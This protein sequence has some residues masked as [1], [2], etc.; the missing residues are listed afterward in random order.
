MEENT[1]QNW[2][3]VNIIEEFSSKRFKEVED[4]KRVEEERNKIVQAFRE[5]QRWKETSEIEEKNKE[6]RIKQPE[7]EKMKIKKI[8]K[9]IRRDVEEE[10]KKRDEEEKEMGHLLKK[11]AV[12]RI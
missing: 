1:I 12:E 9:M 7:E 8:C 11:S 10:N 5:I 6:V 2:Q 3:N 4:R